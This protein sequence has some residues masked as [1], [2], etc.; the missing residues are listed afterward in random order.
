MFGDDI[1]V[2]F[3]ARVP[4]ATLARP[5]GSRS[6]DEPLVGQGGCDGNGSYGTLYI[7]NLDS[8][9]LVLEFRHP[10]GRFSRLVY[11]LV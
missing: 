6:A 3:V 7:R 1:K 5:P 11:A 8:K 9:K 10:F 4:R 2:P